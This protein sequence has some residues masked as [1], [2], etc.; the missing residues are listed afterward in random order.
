MDALAQGKARSVQ[1]ARGR[2]KLRL[3]TL[4]LVVVVSIS[5]SWLLH[6]Q[7][8]AVSP[9]PAPAGFSHGLWHG[10]IMPLALPE[11]LL[12]GDATIYAAHNTGR[13]YNMG[14]ILGVNLCGLVF[15]G[16]FFGRL[17]RWQSA[18]RGASSGADPGGQ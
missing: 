6:A 11:L 8:A 1:P 16:L 4:V 13:G 2:L 18:W 9:G 7:P 10:A 5:L 15:F 14:Y 3:L 17:R 12:G